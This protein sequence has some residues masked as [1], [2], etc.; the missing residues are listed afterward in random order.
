MW[1]KIV[2]PPSPP[3]LE[4]SRELTCTSICTAFQLPFGKVYS[5]FSPKWTFL[6]ALF[7]FELGSLICAISPT[8]VALIVG[9]AIAGIGAAGVFSGALVII[10]HSAPMDKR[11][12][13]QG[14]LGGMFG[15]ASIC[16]PLIG[17]AFTDNVTWRWWVN[18][19]LHSL[20]KKEEEKKRGK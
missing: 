2:P 6:V 17:G 15:I 19:P 3:Y 13:Y 4:L 7:V 16:G 11:P 18:S 5:L 10:A 12:S 20:K 1:R 8:S 9:R 14:M